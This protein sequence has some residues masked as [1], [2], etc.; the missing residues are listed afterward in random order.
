[1]RDLGAIKNTNLRETW[2]SEDDHWQ[3]NIQCCYTIMN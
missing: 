1:M 2:K 3:Y